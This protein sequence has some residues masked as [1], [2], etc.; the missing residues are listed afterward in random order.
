MSN[1][2]VSIVQ[3]EEP[4]FVWE[5]WNWNEKP[6]RMTGHDFPPASKKMLWAEALE[7]ICDKYYKVSR[8]IDWGSWMA[9]ITKP[10]IYE[11]IEEI[12]EDEKVCLEKICFL[13]M[14]DRM[15]DFM[16][17]IDSLEKGKT[18]AI[19]VLET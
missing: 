11:F 17:Y 12:Y 9:R 15:E 14:S 2:S 8:Q 6:P 4:D 13:P 10:Q 3:I 19:M 16:N 7:K 1:I 18:Y 5:K